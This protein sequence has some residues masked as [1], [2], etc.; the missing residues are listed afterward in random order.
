MTMSRLTLALESGELDPLE[1]GV[2][3]L[4]APGDLIYAGFTE[5]LTASQSFF[6]DYARLQAR[7]AQVAAILTD[8]VANSLVICHRS[9]A[10]TLNLIANAITFTKIGGTVCVDGAKT[11]GIE[12]LL[13]ELR[14]TV[15]DV[16]VYS[17]AHGKLI[18]FTRPDG[19][20]DLNAWMDVTYL[21]PN[22]WTTHAASFSS[23]G[24]D[25]GSKL[26]AE[27]LP[28]LKGRVAD[29][30]CGWGYL[31]GEALKSDAITELH[32]L[33]AD[34]HAVACAQ[35]N[36]QDPRASF[37]WCD[38]TTQTGIGFD[39]VVTNPPFHVSRKPDP[40]LGIAFINKA[41]DM[42]KPKGSLWMVANRN[43]PYEAVLEE[44][45]HKV[46]TATQ[47]GGFKVIHAVSPKNT[48]A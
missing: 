32:G 35:N 5:T 42:L 25:A 40:A 22:G 43:L 12:S 21:Y 47:T 7:G 24:P 39:T 34:F 17:K 31:S 1:G 23:D 9:K 3:V 29:L 19:L 18:W 8:P 11:D 13:K 4:N 48:R 10:Q 27:N 6:P 36:V 44:R 45:F 14:K 15:G 37:E 46:Q 28:K 38:V 30:G 20:P 33:E 16:Q 26:L 41:A 2:A